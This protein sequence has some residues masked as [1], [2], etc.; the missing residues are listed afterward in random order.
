[1]ELGGRVAAHLAHVVLAAVVAAE[2][3]VVAAVDAVVAGAP[4]GPR[5]V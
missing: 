2:A 4:P 5:H 1:M 3:A